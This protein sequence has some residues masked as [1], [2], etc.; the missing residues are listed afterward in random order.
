ME[1]GLVQTAIQ[2]IAVFRI[3]LD[4]PEH[5]P[6]A[7]VVDA[8]HRL[9]GQVLELGRVARHHRRQAVGSVS[10]DPAGEPV[11]QIGERVELQ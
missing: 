11:S 3:L 7:V 10:F 1:L 2:Q 9:R 4:V 5:H 6:A 8:A